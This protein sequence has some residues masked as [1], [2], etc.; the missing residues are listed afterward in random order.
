M[1]RGVLILLLAGLALAAVAGGARLADPDPVRD[2]RLT[3]FDYLQRL[4]PR[5]AA[6]LPV[7]VVE[8]DEASLAA[9]GQWPWPRDRM[10]DL[11]SRLAEAGATV[12]V[13]DVL[14]A[15]ADRMSPRRLID[16]AGFDLP[17]DTLPDTDAIFA[18]SLSLA[19]TVL[20][21]A[22]TGQTG[23]APDV[24][25]GFVEVGNSPA[26]G[27]PGAAGFTPL[28]PG[29]A[30]RAEGIGAISIRATEAGGAVRTLPLVW[31]GP[32][33]PVPSLSVEALRLAFGETT[34]TLFGAGD[35]DASMDGLAVGQAFVPTSAQG[36]LWLHYRRDSPDLYVSAR[37][38]LSAPPADWASKVEGH[39]VLVG[40]SAA[41]LL[42]IRTTALGEAVPGV[43]IH[44]QAI[45][46]MLT[47][48]YLTRSDLVGGLEVLVA[49]ALIGAITL[50]MAYSGPVFAVG[51]GAVGAAG[52]L[53]GSWWA[54]ASQATLFDAAFPLVAGGLSFALLAA[55]RLVVLDRERRA[56][57][58]S[59][60]H[61]V[62]PEILAEVERK[63]HRLSLGGETRD[64][65]VLFSDVRG[66]TALTEQLSAEDLVG[67][68][69]TL[70]D[71]LGHEIMHQR[72]TIDKFIGD[73]VMAF[74]NAPLDLAEHAS[75]AV[76][77]GLGMRTAL[78]RLNAGRAEP[79]RMAIG[80]AT[81]PAS[82]GNIGSKNRFNYSVVGET[83]NLAAR[84]EAA[85]R[86]TAADMLVTA[87]VA[88]AAPGFAYL[89]A[90]SLTL[91]GVSGRVR[92]FAVAGDGALAQSAAFQALAREQ[93]ALADALRQG[94]VT[95]LDQV[96]SLAQQAE[97]V[98]PGLGDFILAMPG[99]AA[100]YKPRRPHIRAVSPSG[101]RSPV[102]PW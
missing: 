45:E 62:A 98:A 64:V 53:A 49:V 81:G 28:A 7:R 1:K 100:D 75:H 5:P 55:Y 58:R 43:S 78:A 68:L 16:R 32:D 74:W 22:R 35:L 14:F 18:D 70:F 73:A 19:P 10:A 31:A 93:T 40:T 66:F 24:R 17:A 84:I 37:A 27:L 41:G 42:D 20:G 71:A 3:Y 34:L 8:I 26:A 29:L 95:P 21:I 56:I 72:G 54:F 99:R 65:T 2:L 67:L 38:V 59:F 51:I 97:G 91:K 44:A 48:Q 76:A 101:P 52:T 63:G 9:E 88:E 33:G 30:E 13:Y 46:Q 69:N 102:G 89:D 4:G 80:I 36:E 77:A 94:H 23:S 12:I 39:I 11:Q 86:D 92:S 60:S 61:Y 79:V 85:C 83:V 87:N 90:G 57:R 6:D 82:V 15:E 25:A 96:Q 47:G 50:A